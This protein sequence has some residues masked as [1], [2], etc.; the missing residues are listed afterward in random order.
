MRR[1]QL[2]VLLSLI[3]L[4]LLSACSGGEQP[5]NAEPQQVLPTASPAER[6]PE[7]E[8]PQVPE[9]DPLAGTVIISE[10][11]PHNEA[12]YPDGM[13]AFPDWIELFNVSGNTVSLTGWK[14]SDGANICEIGE[15][16]LEPG[17]MIIVFAGAGTGSGRELRVDFAISAGETITLY[18]PVGG[19]SAEELVPE[20]EKWS[21]VSYIGSDGVRFSEPRTDIGPTPMET[22]SGEG[23]E[24]FVASHDSEG[25]LVINEVQTAVIPGT[26]SYSFGDKDWVELKNISDMALELS[27]YYLSDSS[28]D[29]LKC[30]LPEKTL[31]PGEKVLILCN[32][33][34][35]DGYCN[36]AF[37]LS[38]GGEGI[39]LS[40]GEK[41]TDYVFVPCVPKGC[42]YGRN[43]G[44][45]GFFYIKNPTPGKENSTGC[46]HVSAAP[47]ADSEGGVFDNSEVPQ[48]S[49]FAAGDI[50]YTLDGSMP[51][52][53]SKPYT[54]PISI[55]ETCVV[56]AVS[57]EE[58]AL[59]S[60]SLTLSYFVNEGVT[61]PIISIATDNPNGWRSIYANGFKDLE[62]PG[63]IALYENGKCFEL[64]CGLS[65][66]GYSSLTI[67]KKN[68]KIRF[69]GVYGAPALNYDLFDTG[70]SE[71][72]SLSIR[73]AQ[74]S[75][76]LMF[77]NEI[78]QDLCMG[79]TD[80]VYTQHNKFCI[81]YVNGKY[82]GIFSV[83]E[84]IS[85]QY[86]ANCAGVSKESVSSCKPP[87]VI[88]EVFENEVYWYCVNN[89][90]SDKAVYEHFCEIFNID[91]YID[92]LII[93]GVSN[94][95][96][97]W[98]N[99]RYMRSEETGNK[100]EPV[101]FDLDMTMKDLTEPFENLTNNNFYISTY[102][103]QIINSL[104]SS[105]EFVD[106]LATRYAEVYDTYLSNEK[107]LG[108]IDYYTGLLEP[109]AERDWRE[110][111]YIPENWKRNVEAVK[112]T[113]IEKDWQNY[114]VDC[115]CKY[116][117]VNREDYF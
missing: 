76:Q 17:E 52:E 7:N 115:F 24:R 100:W 99:V 49:L 15:A 85:K 43:D 1:K 54:A 34:G 59:P 62:T 116:I 28:D 55:T 97:L 90:F 86:Y 29:Y 53:Y 102:N 70:I 16:E 48:L 12:V 74:D 3:L 88:D 77:S 96:D 75:D 23:R 79:M 111:Y 37:S 20:C 31:L 56:R 83:K 10:I 27:D 80:K 5:A 108:R 107:L 87:F 113:I 14:L 44:A 68:I 40:D 58:G 95:Y 57:V 63:S 11:M 47:E 89:D 66:A 114:C 2:S 19:V 101:L 35:E 82:Y 18:T 51:T 38:S 84:D 105:P 109:E 117:G 4:L 33:E 46:R 22:N 26:Y 73:A 6:V 42:S 65:V 69:R 112:N 61:L 13:F 50:Y 60:D 39:Y 92:W 106:R 64:N 81:V 21:S 25:P 94:N 67:P 110:W 32:P 9:E 93:E 36:A 104:L 103:R 45:A 91:S 30:R 8:I 78:W 41:L 98:A 71:Y 72:S